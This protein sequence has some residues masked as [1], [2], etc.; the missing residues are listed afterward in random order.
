MSAGTWN[1]H[2]VISNCQAAGLANCLETATNLKADRFTH[3]DFEARKDEILGNVK[4]YR[5]VLVA[6]FIERY[7]EAGALRGKNIVHVPVFNFDGH[8][9]DH[10]NLTEAGGPLR[11][12]Y[13][14]ISLAAFRLGM[15]LRRA[16]ECFNG[17][18]YKALGY[19][20]HWEASRRNFLDSFSRTSRLDLA[21]DLVEWSRRGPLA[22]VPSHPKIACL[23]DIVRR[24]L[25]KAGIAHSGA[26]FLPPDNLARGAAFPVYP[27][28]GS[29]LGVP[30]SYWFKPPNSFAMLSLKDFIAGSYDYFTDKPDLAPTR[31][32]VK[33]Y[34]RALE[35]LA[36]ML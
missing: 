24:V 10:C 4:K 27:E 28:I 35:V 15:P 17:E 34:E 1:R 2:L 12:N 20:D 31:P 30:G 14:I 18:V 21:Q 36:D 5:L 7:C 8:H 26:D 13:S 23:R 32:Y 25:E 9:P 6:P 19:F 11:G 29:R 16:V 3:L 33:R 22:Y